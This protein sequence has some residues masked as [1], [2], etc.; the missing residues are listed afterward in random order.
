MTRDRLGLVVTK[1]EL[2]QRECHGGKNTRSTTRGGVGSS[3]WAWPNVF[4]T[5]A[6]WPISSWA[7]TPTPNLTKPTP[8]FSFLLP[9][10]RGDATQ[11]PVRRRRRGERARGRRHRM[12]QHARLAAFLPPTGRGTGFSPSSLPSLRR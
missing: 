6:L 11:P 12:P 8:P 9:P 3:L 10:L 2:R 1:V 4:S 7:E 5:W